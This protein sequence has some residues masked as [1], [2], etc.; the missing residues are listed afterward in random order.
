MKRR[1]RMTKINKITD[2]QKGHHVTHLHACLGATQ[3]SIHLAPV[4]GPFGSSTRL[5]GVASQVLRFGV[6]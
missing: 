3:V 4:Q 2:D 6:R 5:I 1:A